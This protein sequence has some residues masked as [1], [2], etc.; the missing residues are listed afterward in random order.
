MHFVLG[1]LNYFMKDDA[2]LKKK[3][4]VDKEENDGGTKGIK[5]EVCQEQNCFMNSALPFI[6][7]TKTHIKGY[8]IHI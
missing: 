4:A 3:A 1:V 7:K 8:S 5:L 2:M 6:D